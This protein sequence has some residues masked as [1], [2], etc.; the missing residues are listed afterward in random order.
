MTGPGRSRRRSSKTLSSI[1]AEDDEAWN[2]TLQVFD[3]RPFRKLSFVVRFAWAAR[4]HPAVLLLGSVSRRDLYQDLVIGVL[5]RR[6]TNRHARL[7]LTDCTWSPG[8]A[9]L[10]RGRPSVGRLLAAAHRGLV[11]LL[12][13]PH[14]VFCVLSEA[15]RRR[16]PAAWGV[17]PERVVVTPFSHTLWGWAEDDVPA[18]GNY[19]FA[20]GDSMRDYALLAE[21][22]RGLDGRVV[23][24]TRKTVADAPPNMEVAP[25]SH[26]EFLEQLRGAGVVV[27]PLQDDGY[28]SAGQQTYLNAMALG[29]PVVVTDALGVREVVTDG[30]DGVVVPSKPEA[31]RAALRRCLTV[32]AQPELD[33]MA[34]RAR[35]TVL[36]RYTPRAYRRRVLDVV[37]GTASP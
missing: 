21:A 14:T 17:P 20:G 5:V 7:V 2:E 8:S 32:E 11:R 13:G 29:K 3:R 12:D 6:V 25:V 31:I 36:G 33:R 16:F 30:V 27:V 9:T 28:R 35:E 1:W 26:E 15:E 18:R 23:V 37:T 34:R 24:A 22:C 10:S 4:Q 19:V